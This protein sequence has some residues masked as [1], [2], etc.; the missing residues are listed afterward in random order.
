L[1]AIREPIRRLD[2]FY[3][4]CIIIEN[5]RLRAIE[6]DNAQIKK[7]L[8]IVPV[9]SNLLTVRRP[10]GNESELVGL[11]PGTLLVRKTALLPGG[12]FINC[13]ITGIPM[14]D[15]FHPPDQVMTWLRNPDGSSKRLPLKKFP[16]HFGG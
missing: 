6:S 15:L 8:L 7:F 12:L 4:L 13:Q 9:I 16:I 3:F 2:I 11:L 14:T 5:A 10:F 1:P